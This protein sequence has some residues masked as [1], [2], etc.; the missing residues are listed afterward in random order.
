MRD[1]K[2][3]HS[4]VALDYEA[5]SFRH[6]REENGQ[7]YSLPDGQILTVG[8]ERFECGEMIFRPEKFGLRIPSLTRLLFDAL[9]KCDIDT[10]RDF[11]YNC[12]LT[13]G[14]RISFIL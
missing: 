12:V 4:Y 1:I 3:K 14:K 11:S 9:Q 7:R 6:D 8:K 2:E 10:R 13:G 5:E